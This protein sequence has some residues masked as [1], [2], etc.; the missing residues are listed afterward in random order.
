[1]DFFTQQEQARRRT[2]TL[3]LL[4]VLAVLAIVLAVNAVAALL[5]QW[6]Q[7]GSLSRHLNYPSGFFLANTL[8]TVGLIAGGTLIEL[9]NLR[10]GGDVVA[11]M[12]GGRLV[13]P[14]TA[15]ADERRLINVVEE[16]A[17]ASGIACPKV[18]L[19]D[20]EEAINAFAAGYNPGDAVVAVTRGTLQRLTRDELQ[21]VVAHEFSHI[22]N[23]DM[24]LNVRLLGLLF[25]IQMI[26]HFGRHLLESGRGGWGFRSRAG[27]A[28][29]R[30]IMLIMG[31]AL[32][33][34][35][36]IG[37]LFG[38]LIKAAVSREREFLADASA[39]QFTRNAD[40][41]GG[42]LRKIGGLT[43][44]TGLGSR[45]NHPNAEQLSHF[46]LGA[47]RP[48]LLAGLFATH[49][50]L[51]ERLRRLYGRHM[52]ALDA[53]VLQEASA[54]AAMLPDIPF[55]AVN[56]FVAQAALP[57]TPLP[58]RHALGAQL[59]AEIRHA[60]HIDAAA[61]DPD[62]AAALVLGLT[63]QRADAA[64][65]EETDTRS[66]GNDR[67]ARHAATLTQHAP[68]H[69]QQALRLAR[70]IDRLPPEARLPLLDL[71]VPALKALPDE[72]K[73]RLLD[74]V[75]AL[76]AADAR[77]TIAEFVLQTLLARRLAPHAARAVPV[78]HANLQA[79]RAEC[80]LLLSLVAHVRA[81]AGPPALRAST[82]QEAFLQGARGADIGVSETDL[83][84]AEKIRFETVRT[85]L[86][87]ANR[88]APLAKPLFIKALVRAAGEQPSHTL[89]DLLR[90]VCSTLDAPLPPVLDAGVRATPRGTHAIL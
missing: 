79:L 8:I 69:A 62:A 52:E 3:V 17:L 77:V 27:N 81:S 37:I 9:F 5:W 13:A 43:R 21:G 28:S 39:V 25:G 53:P 4:M 61:H 88:L 57:A 49:P 14:G 20:K 86:E 16:M 29:P 46:F 63:V 54:V 36:Y 41:L 22:L 11:R 74:A 76:I 47:P 55:V 44:A 35:G 89:A 26:A 51:T 34:I 24:R 67:F 56:N 73:Q 40:G 60:P 1:M 6:M 45:I 90:A 85:A 48:N 59:A 31:I 50:P 65:Q 68:Q 42:A 84:P 80:A 12:A 70:E 10:E 64:H 66:A 83:V 19:L 33:V 2:R 78:R 87:R 30:N 18:Y 7:G 23:G 72:E 71:A 82:A 32:F 15:R 75:A 58:S 38:R